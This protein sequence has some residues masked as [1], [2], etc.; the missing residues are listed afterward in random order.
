MT[1]QTYI[2]QN[3]YIYDNLHTS[4]KLAPSL[5]PLEGTAYLCIKFQRFLGVVLLR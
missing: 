3:V 2:Y 1:Y 4:S 5:H